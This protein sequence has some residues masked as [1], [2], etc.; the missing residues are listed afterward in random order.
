MAHTG[1]RAG[2]TALPTDNSGT[3]TEFGEAVPPA[4][5][6]L[7]PPSPRSDGDV[8]EGSVERDRHSRARE[9]GDVE[10]DDDLE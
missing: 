5:E 8:A 7:P 6:A 3:V 9:V 1:S 2:Q 4:M 10:G